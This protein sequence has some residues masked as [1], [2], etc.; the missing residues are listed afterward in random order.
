MGKKWKIRKS[1]TWKK[2]IGN[3]LTTRGSK[4]SGHGARDGINENNS[5][6]GVGMKTK[7]EK[8]PK[9]GFLDGYKTYDTKHGF[10][11]R[12]EWRS[13]W[14]DRMNHKDASATIGADDPL[15]VMGFSSL[16]TRGELDQRYRALVM[17]HHPDRGGDPAEF[18]H[19]QAAWS[20]LTEK[21]ME[22]K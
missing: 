4:Q 9:K 7:P 18:K 1:K 5:K 22:K 12:S 17:Q 2:F 14:D 21:L 6:C 11:N 13:A 15:S 10:G 3:T 19:V 16:P 8:K 20:L